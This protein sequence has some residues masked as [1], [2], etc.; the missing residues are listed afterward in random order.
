MRVF[1]ILAL[2]VLTFVTLMMC[3][4]FFVGVQDDV[5]NSDVAIVL[6]AAVHK[7]G[8]P[9]QRLAARLDKT[10]ELYRQGR[11]AHIIASGGID[12]EHTNEAQAMYK[13]LVAQGIPADAIWIDSQG[14]NTLAT[15]KNSAQLMQVHHLKSALVISQFFHIPRIRLALYAM[16]VQEVHSAYPKYFERR[17]VYSVL[18]EVVAIPY[19]FGVEYLR[20]NYSPQDASANH[21]SK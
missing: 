5:S 19:Y 10:V 7:N 16:G 12:Q 3:C 9:S 4:I 15:A 14:A 2:L 18:R 8:H 20:F 1:K 11:F 6:G 13:Y 17:D 21:A